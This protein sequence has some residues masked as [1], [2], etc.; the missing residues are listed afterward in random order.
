M[1]GAAG[2]GRADGE[3]AT[4]SSLRVLEPR[5]RG[6]IAIA[7][8][9][10]LVGFLW[11]VADVPRY[12]A[13]ATV[14][15]EG[16]GGAP[17]EG[18]ELAA[19]AELGRG[20]RV[21]DIAAGLIG[22]D[23]AGADLLSDIEI[24][25]DP[26]AGAVRIEATADSPDFAASAANGYALAL[27][28]NGGKKFLLGSAA[29][30]SD[31]P[32]ANRSAVGWSLIGLLAGLLLAGLVVFLR[33]RLPAA[34]KIGPRRRAS[35]ERRPDPEPADLSE[36][37]RAEDAFGVPVLAS[38]DDPADLV[39]LDDG[40]IEIDRADAV[41]LRDLAGR[42]GF[43]EPDG[44]RTLAV[45]DVA[46]GDGALPV[47]AG[48][49][50]AAG[51]LGLRAILVEGDLRN[52][53]LAATLDVEPSP[54]LRDYLQ[55]SASPREVLRSAQVG[56]GDGEHVPLVCVPAGDRRVDLPGGIDGARF[57]ALLERLPRVYD[58]VLL[59]GPPV[60]PGSDAMAI[61]ELMDGVLLVSGDDE[62]AGERIADAADSLPDERLLAGILT[63]PG[64]AQERPQR[65]R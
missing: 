62:D 20:S 9:G 36:P 11:G 16:K 41:T 6:I 12:S 24:S 55:G 38:F 61:A 57:E 3:G 17:A 29:A 10:L 46:A 8:A 23:V 39:L 60:R 19:A 65:S 63:R 21:A 59:S 64:A 7:L 1:T 15:V 35:A 31:E 5:T 22:D 56:D 14:L 40:E 54:G 42:L 53:L 49:A 4:S 34:G 50:I 32:S 47:L 44:P 58:I 26:D 48:L 13:A 30:L 25:P 33:A 43:G 18:T 28:K 51:E 37:L 52:P 27:V 45:F 2:P